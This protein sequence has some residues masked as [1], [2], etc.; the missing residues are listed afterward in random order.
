MLHSL[1]ASCMRIYMQNEQNQHDPLELCRLGKLTSA[2]WY[3]LTVTNAVTD[4]QH[5]KTYDSLES[6]GLV[7][8]SVVPG[9]CVRT[10]LGDAVVHD[11][12]RRT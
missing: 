5:G 9:H 8:R 3:L 10:G 4:N 6:K 12:V 7:T 2:E 11:K 1:V